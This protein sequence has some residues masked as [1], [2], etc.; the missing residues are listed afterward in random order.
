M[1]G[2]ASISA[3]VLAAYAAD[4]ALEVPGVTA[5][6]GESTL[7]RHRPVRVEDDGAV[8]VEL[9]VTVDWGVSVPELGRAVQRRVGEYLERMADVVP[10]AVDV[11]V[12][13]VGA[14]PA[15]SQ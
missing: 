8:R 12:D 5:V 14:P 4:A 2:H 3:E 11:V 7:H 13:G 1:E 9:H 10:L 6:E 15:G